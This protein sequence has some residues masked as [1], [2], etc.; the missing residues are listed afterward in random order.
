[1]A[2]TRKK[3]T[4]RARS[5]APLGGMMAPLQ[6]PVV[7]L[8]VAIL[9]TR[10]HVTVEDWGDSNALRKLPE[11]QS[12]RATTA[13]CAAIFPDP[14]AS[15][16]GEQP[17]PSHDGFV[18]CSGCHM[19]RDPSY[20]GLKATIS[21]GSG[22]KAFSRQL[23][24]ANVPKSM[25]GRLAMPKSILAPGSV[26]GW[27]DLFTRFMKKFFAIDERVIV[28]DLGR[29]RG[30]PTSRPL[31]CRDAI[32]IQALTGEPPD[33]ELC[34]AYRGGGQFAQ[35]KSPLKKPL[36]ALLTL[37]GNL[38]RKKEREGKKIEVAMVEAPKEYASRKR[39]RWDEPSPPIDIPEEDFLELLS[40]WIKDG[41]VTLPL[42][43]KEPNTEERKNSKFCRYHRRKSHHTMDCYMLFAI[44]H[45]KV[46]NGE[47]R[48]R[49]RK[50]THR[51]GSEKEKEVIMTIAE[52][53]ELPSEGE[54]RIAKL[55]SDKDNQLKKEPSM[56][57]LSSASEHPKGYEGAKR[58]D[59]SKTYYR[60]WY[61]LSAAEHV[62]LCVFRSQSGTHK[63]EGE[64][65]PSPT[66][67]DEQLSRLLHAEELKAPEC[68]EDEVKSTQGE[69]Q[70]LAN[71][72]YST[73]WLPTLVASWKLNLECRL[74]RSQ[75]CPK[76]LQL[77]FL[78]AHKTQRL[79]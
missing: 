62:G 9:L 76:R 18:A 75:A 70:E 63:I 49:D 59:Y 33:F 19:G 56:S 35:L 79:L 36:G 13:R 46:S 51:E 45:K 78:P 17:P 69:L 73:P 8:Q 30:S 60:L 28:V 37:Q 34:Q 57:W 2:P 26:F 24:L 77:P 54:E 68:M 21:G 25:M 41:V 72:A 29:D 10:E 61:K 48:F 39:E 12:C 3:N 40:T 47:I 53:G 4:A 66:N 14:S 71:P 50:K 5:P 22:S 64:A 44:F 52:K 1:M 16:A 15:S 38:E 58:E 65:S 11:G 7:P 27:S 32:R 6:N 31:H 67:Q 20:K 74:Y 23:H 42:I 43:K 55:V